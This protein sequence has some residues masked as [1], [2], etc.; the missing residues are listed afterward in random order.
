MT[1][2]IT[3]DDYDDSDSMHDE[4]MKTWEV[5]VAKYITVLEMASVTSQARVSLLKVLMEHETNESVKTVVLRALQ[6]ELDVT[7]LTQQLQAG[8]VD[9]AKM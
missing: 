3:P 6:G 4:N 7:A 8:W 2:F 9:S 1:L 5:S